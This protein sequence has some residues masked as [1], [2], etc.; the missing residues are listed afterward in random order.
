MEKNILR[1]NFKFFGLRISKNYYTLSEGDLATICMQTFLQRFRI[2]AKNFLRT[3]KDEDLEREIKKLIL[4]DKYETLGNVVLLYR[5]RKISGWN[6]IKNYKVNMDSSKLINL[7]ESNAKILQKVL[8]RSIG[9][10]KNNYIQGYLYSSK[11]ILRNDVWFVFEKEKKKERYTHFKKMERLNKDSTYLSLIINKKNRHIRILSNTR[12][13]KEEE[14]I[15]KFLLSRIKNFNIENIDIPTVTREGIIK[16]IEQNKSKIYEIRFY[17]SGDINSELK[18]RNPYH[19]PLSKEINLLVDNEILSFSE[20]ENLKEIKLKFQ[21]I[22]KYYNFYDCESNII[23]SI[24]NKYRRGTDYI[25][26]QYRF[27]KER[28]YFLKNILSGKRFNHILLDKKQMRLINNLDSAGWIKIIGYKRCQKCKKLNRIYEKNCSKCSADLEDNFSLNNFYCEVREEKVREWLKK[29]LPRKYNIKT[30]KKYIKR[31]EIKLD[32][33]YSLNEEVFLLYD[34]GLISREFLKEMVM[35]NMQILFLDK[36]CRGASISSKD[37]ENLGVPYISIVDLIK[38]ENIEEIKRKIKLTLTNLYNKRFERMII[39]IEKLRKCSDW[40]EFEIYCFNILAGLFIKADY[41]GRKHSGLSVP[42]GLCYLGKFK[43]RKA[44]LSWDCKF[45]E[46][47]YKILNDYYHN[48]SKHRKYIR[49]INKK[50]KALKRGSLR[51]YAIVSNNLKKEDFDQFTELNKIRK[52]NGKIV[53][54]DSGALLEIAE[55]IRKN[56]EDFISQ[57]NK[58]LDPLVSILCDKENKI[59]RIDKKVVKG[60]LKN[61]R[62]EKRLRLVRNGNRS[63]IVES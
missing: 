1:D 10:R 29:E 23:L 34:E 4:T 11:F 20:L 44:W 37:L 48:P 60:I 32:R 43:N 13:S 17:A 27:Y 38:N 28:D 55:F 24:Y 54:I 31:T 59:N 22:E 46:K 49:N 18:I 63:S 30:S 12:N 62:I 53:L 25:P 42:D 21:D 51:S 57:R 14:T 56:L 2:A 3:E 8:N 45:S 16:D 5:L 41:W 6:F 36:F 9:K 52:W 61:I 47:E 15:K 40:E 58:V 50:I 35:R 7:L 33:I 19:E 26:E 39:T